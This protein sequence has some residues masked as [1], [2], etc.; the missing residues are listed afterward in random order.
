MALFKNRIAQLSIAVLVLT[1]FAHGQQTP[2]YAVVQRFPL[3]QQTDGMDGELRVLMDS[4]INADLKRLMWNQGPWD[5]SLPDDA[6]A[7]RSFQSLAP[8]NAKLEIAD[9]RG[10]VT[11]DKMLPYPLVEVKARLFGSQQIFFLTI[12]D[13]AGYGSYSGLTTTLLSVDSSGLKTVEAFDFYRKARTPI[14][15]AANSKSGWKEVPRQGKVDLLAF[16]CAANL[17]ALTYIPRYNGSSIDQLPKDVF[18]VHYVRYRFD[19]DA[20]TRFERVEPGYWESNQPFPSDSS[21][22]E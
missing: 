3:T 11:R 20:W 12:D 10:I 4:R 14:A 18:L 13:S 17:N 16:Y 6:A 21:F 15:V 2:K 5:L 8:A 1:L 22:P 9:A 7:Y 19:G